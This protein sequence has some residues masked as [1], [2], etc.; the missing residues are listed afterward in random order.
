MKELG[1]RKKDKKN[2]V[3][4]EI[5]PE[6]LKR[7][8][9]R[10]AEEE[11]RR[12]S[13]HNRMLKTLPTVDSEALKREREREAEEER[14]WRSVHNRML[15]TLLTVEPKAESSKN[16]LNVST[17]DIEG[18]V[19]QEDD[20]SFHL[21]TNLKGTTSLLAQM[22]IE[23]KRTAI[24]QAQKALKD[25]EEKIENAETDEDREKAEKEKE[26][27]KDAIKHQLKNLAMAVVNEQQNNYDKHHTGK[28][29]SHASLMKIIKNVPSEIPK[30]NKKY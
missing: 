2:G 1:N 17:K 27:V 18:K 20:G 4:Q 3:N 24:R 28:L 16:A 15:K 22:Q 8:R 12:R 13:V 10:E 9:E 7:E 21:E 14:R 19:I 29:I 5:D 6:A 25:V 30:P 26:A 11:R 23:M